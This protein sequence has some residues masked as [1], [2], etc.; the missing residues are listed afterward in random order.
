MDV[1][2]AGLGA[3]RALFLRLA[4]V[5]GRR[6]GEG[7]GAG[8]IEM[9]GRLLD[10][11]PDWADLRALARREGVSAVL[12]PRLR[13]VL[14]ATGA[15]RPPAE[16]EEALR[17]EAMVGEFHAR[18]LEAR[19]QDV[20]EL[21]S[22]GGVEPVL[23][24]G[25]GL[26]YTVHGGMARRPMGD[27][28]LLIP[29]EAMPA[30]MAALR[31]A[32][33][34]PEQA[35]RTEEHY[36]TH[37][38]AP[39]MVEPGGGTAV[40]ELHDQ[41]VPPGNPFNFGA[42]RMRARARR[43]PSPLGEVLV[44][45]MADQLLHVAIHLAWSH[46]LRWGAWRAIADVA[47][48]VA[49]AAEADAAPPGAGERPTA[50][51]LDEIVEEAR[52]AGAGSCVYWTLRLAAALGGARVPEPWLAALRP[53]GAVAALE[54]HLAHQLLP[55]PGVVPSVR[56]GRLGWTAAIRPGWSGHGGARPWLIGVGADMG[57]EEG[58]RGGQGVRED[59]RRGPSGRGARWWR[60]LGTLAR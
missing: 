33:W 35:G 27:I 13:R 14:D 46:E 38:H 52:W 43:V 22:S 7:A 1:D 19:L 8:A 51:T 6:A 47:A 4:G 41:L 29:R 32:G 42:G 15:P 59:I 17:H 54:R 58:D 60:Y 37:Q 57:A 48:I 45:S 39:P 24:K 56:L 34:T 53:P 36:S 12:W 2:S 44:P 9:A 3:T 28:D 26:A 55:G 10:R 40:V 5:V 20:L 49:V 16:V 21:L 50:R 31:S 23:L 11:S 18:R 30:A 25:A